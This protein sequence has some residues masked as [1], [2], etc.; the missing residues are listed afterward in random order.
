MLTFLVTDKG[1]FWMFHVDLP[2]KVHPTEAVYHVSLPVLGDG[3]C[4][5]GNGELKG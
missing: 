1:N 5:T 4:V 2:P 3:V